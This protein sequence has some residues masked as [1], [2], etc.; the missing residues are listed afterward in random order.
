MTVELETLLN[1]VQGLGPFADRAAA[2][3]AIEVVFGALRRTLQDDEVRWLREELDTQL[4]SWLRHGSFAGD[5][6]PEQLYEL[7]A[8]AQGVNQGLAAEQVQVVARALTEALPPPIVSRLHVALPQLAELLSPAAVTQTPTAGRS[9]SAP[10]PSGHTLAEGRPGGT[11]P[12]SSSG[13]GSTHPVSTAHPA[14][15]HTHSL[16]RS[17]DPH[18]DSKLSSARGLTQ[19]REGESLSTTRRTPGK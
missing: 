15:A 2:T 13:P 12:L 4:A 14:D 16:A 3:K 1:R 17:D 10:R 5:Q 6:T 7:V 18:A 19:E 11:R 9:A 8:H